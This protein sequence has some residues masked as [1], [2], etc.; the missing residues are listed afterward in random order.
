V[1]LTVRGSYADLVRYL[2]AVERLPVRVH[3]GRAVL[4]ASQYPNVDLRLTVYTLGMDRAWL[5]L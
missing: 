5:A 3:F 4:D 2:D 1:E